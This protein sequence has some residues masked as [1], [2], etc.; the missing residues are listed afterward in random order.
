MW[1]CCTRS[2]DATG[3]VCGGPPLT[4]TVALQPE[5]HATERMT[6]AAAGASTL[7]VSDFVAL[8]TTSTGRRRPPVVKAESG[9]GGFRSVNTA[10]PWEKPADCHGPGTMA[11]ESEPPSS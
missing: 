7:I 4:E 9:T 8:E 10:Y 3:I 1:T 5:S 6:L 11:D 2:N